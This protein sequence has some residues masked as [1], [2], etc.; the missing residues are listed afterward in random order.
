MSYGVGCRHGSDPTLLWLWCRLEAT[1]LIRLLGW[2]P[3][4]ATGVALEKTEKKNLA[5]SALNIFPHLLDSPESNQSLTAAAA[6][7][8]GMWGGCPTHSTWALTPYSGPLVP[9]L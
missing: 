9:F 7:T 8:P 1:A 3:P 5:P 4:C 6:H 2:E